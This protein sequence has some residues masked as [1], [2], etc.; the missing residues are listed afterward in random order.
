MKGFVRLLLLGLLFALPG[1][2]CPA[3]AAESLRAAVASNFIQPFR[4]MAAAFQAQTGIA[5]EATY[6]SSG[7]LYNQILAGAPYDLFLSADEDCPTFLFQAEVSEKPFVYA[8]GRVI[9][10][11][12]RKDFCRADN[13][14]TALREGSAKRVSLANP[15]TAP[16]GLA[17]IAVLEKAGLQNALKSR[18]IFSQ[19]IAQAFQHASTG[20]VDACLCAAS[21]L[22]AAEGRAGCH[23][24]LGEAAEVSQGAC[25]LKRTKKPE[26]A[27]RIAAFLLT[28]Q[29]VEIKSRYGYR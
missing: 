3:G 6:A 13:W 23:Y 15:A 1:M 28:P 26:L 10:W 16:Y 21:C 11:S 9:L 18:L 25:V 4:E 29:A 24:E 14:Q 17:A 22:A 12:S 8:R 5:V 19:D 2:P 20:A 7:T 27:R